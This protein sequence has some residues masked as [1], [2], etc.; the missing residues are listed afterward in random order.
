MKVPTAWISHIQHKNLMKQHSSHSVM[1]NSSNFPLNVL[2]CLYLFVCPSCCYRTFLVLKSVRYISLISIWIGMCHMCC[3]WYQMCSC[4]VVRHGVCQN[5]LSKKQ[6]C[7]LVFAS[8]TF[9]WSK[10][11][12]YKKEISSHLSSFT[13]K[14]CLKV[15]L[16]FS[17][18]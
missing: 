16:I 7:C 11:A 6:S 4:V 17:S 8:R 18:P 3:M 5:T 14:K 9:T 2:S 15:D 12:C 13:G 1:F 10:T